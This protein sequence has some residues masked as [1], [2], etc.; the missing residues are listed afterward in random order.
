MD[1]REW[2]ETVSVAE[3]AQVNASSAPAEA[4]KLVEMGEVSVETKGTL[5]GLELGL[6][7]RSY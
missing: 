3:Q 2:V 4:V 1:S 6:T 5:R 7:P